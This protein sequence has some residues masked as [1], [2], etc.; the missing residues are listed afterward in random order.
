MEDVTSLLLNLSYGGTQVKESI[1]HLLLDG[2]SQL[3]N[4]VSGRVSDLLTDLAQ[5][6]ASCGLTT[7][8]RKPKR[9]VKILNMKLKSRKQM[10][11]TI[12]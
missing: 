11:F 4:M 6:K 9:L 2:A 12:Y 1:L 8:S 5:I 3:G 7:L 10:L